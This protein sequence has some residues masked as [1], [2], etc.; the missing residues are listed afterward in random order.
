[1]RSQRKKILRSYSNALVEQYEQDG[2]FPRFAQTRY[3]L[4]RK[5]DLRELIRS[6]YEAEPRVFLDLNLE[7]KKTLVGLFN[8]LLDSGERDS[9]LT[10]IESVIN[11]EKKEQEELVALLKTTTLNR[12]I[13]TIK[14]LEDRYQAVAYIKQLVFNHD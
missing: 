7:Q 4:E 1:L 3:D 12:I 2:A 10:I 5:S 8:V 9:V 13:R 14:M 6:F 11:L